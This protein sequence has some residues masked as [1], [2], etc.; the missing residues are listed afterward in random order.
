MIGSKDKRLSSIVI[1]IKNQFLEFI[2]RKIEKITQRFNCL[3]F[4]NIDIIKIVD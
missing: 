3:K 1:H 2:A 4:F